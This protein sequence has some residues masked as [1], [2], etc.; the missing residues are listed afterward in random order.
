M[1]FQKLSRRSLALI[2]LIGLVVCGGL[3]RYFTRTKLNQPFELSETD[4]NELKA[5]LEK[6]VREDLATRKAS[7][8][9]SVSISDPQ[10]T[11]VNHILIAYQFS[12]DDATGKSAANNDA[13][14]DGQVTHEMKAVA[15]LERIPQGWQIGDVVSGDED[16]KFS[17]PLV[18][19]TAPKKE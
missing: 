16:L 6:I 7:K 12:Y 11:D 8:I 5:E 10:I 18:I 1:N 3:I 13:S 4:R 17:T 2:L 19:Q 15:H 14:N 9:N